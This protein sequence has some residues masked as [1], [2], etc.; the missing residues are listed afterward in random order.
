M[1]G[2]ATGQVRALAL[3]QAAE[4]ERIP[5]PLLAASEFVLVSNAT[6]Y[7]TVTESGG[8][9]ILVTRSFSVTDS[10]GR[11]RLL[12]GA[13]IGPWRWRRVLL[14]EG[15]GALAIVGGG[16]AAAFRGAL[17]FRVAAALAGTRVVKAC[18][19]R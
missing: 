2:A 1:S 10:R 9:P 7:A 18:A 19:A 5:A 11:A 8:Q 3:P 14:N 17:G 13:L 6:Q 12:L 4:A 15:I 16:G